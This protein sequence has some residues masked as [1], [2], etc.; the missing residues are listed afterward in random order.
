M[1]AI[2]QSFF[3][4]ASPFS[5]RNVS[6]QQNLSYANCK[7]KFSSFIYNKT[8]STFYWTRVLSPWSF[9]FLYIQLG[10]VR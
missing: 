7:F 8:K 5:L 10:A 9:S 2:D 1:F 3:L 6:N 4:T